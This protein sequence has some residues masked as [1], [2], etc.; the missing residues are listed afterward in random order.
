MEGSKG[1]RGNQCVHGY[2]CEVEH[3]TLHRKTVL[4]E[5]SL[6]HFL[7]R[8]R[9]GHSTQDALVNLVDE[10]RE[11]L[12]SD[13]LVGSVFLDFSKVFDTVDCSILFQKLTWYGVGDEL[14]WFEAREK[15]EGV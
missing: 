15:A 11:A 13:V 5:P 8:F 7:V 3:C 14:K 4:D 9:P 10:W 1:D 12:D 6:T 2:S